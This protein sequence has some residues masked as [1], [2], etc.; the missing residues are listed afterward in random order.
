MSEP[1][2]AESNV[3][4]LTRCLLDR[5]YSDGILSYCC[6]ASSC[7]Y[8]EVNG[9]KSFLLDDDGCYCNSAIEAGKVLCGLT[10]TW[11][12]SKNKAL[13]AGVDFVAPKAGC[14][15]ATPEKGPLSLY[16]RE[17]SAPIHETC[18]AIKARHPRAKSGIYTIDLGFG[19]SKRKCSAKACAACDTKTSCVDARGT[20][21]WSG[22]TCGKR[23]VSL[24]HFRYTHT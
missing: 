19:N 5:R 17:A 12:A 22:G 15:Y 7:R 24:R 20:C 10:N 16:F 8:R 1:Q 9:I 14:D 2:I 13:P 11:G 21:R 18:A 3:T 4:A 23:S 6:V